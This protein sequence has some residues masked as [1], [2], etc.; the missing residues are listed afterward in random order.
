VRPLTGSI[1]KGLAWGLVL[2]KH[3]TVSRATDG[4]QRPVRLTHGLPLF[5]RYQKVGRLLMVHLPAP[6]R[7]RASRPHPPS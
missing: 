2:N 1:T 7:A 4:E 6:P 3:L 5:E